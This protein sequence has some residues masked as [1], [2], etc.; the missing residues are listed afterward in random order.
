MVK[1]SSISKLAD[2]AR[3]AGVGNATVSRALNGGKNVGT[4]KM[5]RILAAV[6][7]L[8]YRPNRVARLLRGA[9]SG[10]IGMVVPSISDLFYS[11]CAESV[12]AVVR[13]HNALLVVVATHDEVAAISQTVQNLMLH[14][15]DGLVMACPKAPD[16]RVINLLREAKIPVVA[17]DGPLTEVGCPSVLCANF[18]G[19]VMATEHLLEHGYRKVIS[20]QIKPELYTMRERLRGYRSA[21]KAAG[22]NIYEET[23][24]DQASAIEVLRRYCG[25]KNPPG[26]FAANNLTARYLCEAVHILGLS[27]PRELA[28]LSFDDF[29]LAETLTPP[30]SVVRQPL[31]QI[32]RTAARLLFEQK[33]D[34]DAGSKSRSDQ[35]IFLS[36][37]LILRQSCGCAHRKRTPSAVVPRRLTGRT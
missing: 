21:I 35:R 18:D 29:D 7:D 32:G 31:E 12:E 25:R 15:I 9:S 23:I 10:I 22:R 28:L 34:S 8:N 5:A 26:I 33:A 20:V 17:I 11:H 2:V 3:R 6:E 37:Q 16:Q 4:E 14:Q 36:P 30:M 1:S 19:A 24:T 27:I 13:E